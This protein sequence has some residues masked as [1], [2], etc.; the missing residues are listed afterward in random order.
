MPFPAAPPTVDGRL[1]TVDRLMREPLEISRDLAEMSYQ[2]YFGEVL[3]TE[4]EPAPAGAVIYD[5]ITRN[6]LFPDRDVARHTPGAQF[7]LVISTR[8]NPKTAY[9]EEYGGKFYVTYKAI[10]RNRFREVERNERLLANA[11][12][13]KWNNIA[14][15]LLNATVTA[16][17]VSAII[18]GT[19][20]SLFDTDIYG[21]LAATQFAADSRELGLVLDTVIVNPAQ[22]LDIDTNDKLAKRLKSILDA[23]GQPLLATP[24]TT[25]VQDFTVLRSYRQTPGQ[26]LVLARGDVGGRHVEPEGEAGENVAVDPDSGI[27]TQVWDDPENTRRWVQSWKSEVL[28]VDNPFAVYRIEG[29]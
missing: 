24:G 5:E 13:R 28:Y 2:H 10:Q 25:Q 29:I 17:G 14:V 6:D 4:G 19:D 26:A 18:P 22:G 1:V 20:W 9:A 3:F 21:H 7:P 12:V 27:A 8:P 15:D 11:L 23:Q 16:V